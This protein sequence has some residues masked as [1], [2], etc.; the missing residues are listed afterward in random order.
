MKFCGE[1]TKKNGKKWYEATTFCLRVR[2][3]RRV[4]E[5]YR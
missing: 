5:R 1:F 2:G 3:A 4:S